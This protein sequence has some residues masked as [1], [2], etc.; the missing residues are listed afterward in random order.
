MARA[1]HQRLSRASRSTKRAPISGPACAA[2]VATGPRSS[3]PTTSPSTSRLSRKAIVGDVN[4]TLLRRAR[5][6]RGPL[7]RRSNRQPKVTRARAEGSRRQA[8]PALRRLGLGRARRRAVAR[9]RAPER[10][11]PAAAR[12]RAAHRLERQKL[13]AEV[14]LE[15]AAHGARPR[16]ELR[17]QP[18]QPLREPFPESVPRDAGRLDADRLEQH[19]RLLRQRPARPRAPVARRRLDRRRPSSNAFHG[20]ERARRATRTAQRTTTPSRIRRSS[21]TRPSAVARTSSH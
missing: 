21:S 2:R 11:E 10:S 1:A 17:H 14:T 19:E 5:R 4:A 13:V 18:R 8:E 16:R 9:S 7:D 15:P 20:P 6:D 3:Y 12:G